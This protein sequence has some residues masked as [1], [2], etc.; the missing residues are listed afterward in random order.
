MVH[1]AFYDSPK[2]ING[3][4]Q[5]PGLYKHIEMEG[6]SEAKKDYIQVTA[7]QY[8]LDPNLIRAVISVESHGNTNAIG[9][10]GESYGLMQIQPRWHEAR[11]Q[12]LGVTNLLDPNE[13]VKLGCDILAELIDKYGLEGALNAY[14][15]GNPDCNNGYAEK[16]KAEQLLIIERK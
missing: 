13:N 8:G 5:G 14:N 2:V 16:I 12:R 10:N 6:V 7:E 4:N 11:M 3:A 1:I 15:T 9:D